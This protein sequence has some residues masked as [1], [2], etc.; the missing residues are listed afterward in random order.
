VAS[1]ILKNVRTWVD[2]Y[3]MTGDT[4]SGSLDLDHEVFDVTVNQPPGS[5]G[6]RARA[7]G[8]EDVSA[9]TSG[10]WSTGAGSVDEDAFTSLGRTDAVLTMSPDGLEG[11][12]AYTLRAGRLK[13]SLL[14][15]HGG[16]APFSLDFAG[17]HGETTTVRG[18]VVKTKG[19]VSATGATGTGQ[20]L[21]AVTA[22]QHLYASLHL[23][24]AGTTLTA[25]VES[26]DNSG[27]TSPTTRLTLGPVTAAGGVWA[28]RLAGPVT[29]TWYRLRISA[30]TGTFTIAAV[31]GIR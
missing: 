9:Q 31:V 7:C 8:L 30:I 19:A 25:V 12:V 15:A 10:F 4:N 1:T 11:S 18:L 2:G 6:A 26:D 17:S 21:G 20:Q 23:F 27:F 14:G 29:D 24:S 22:D 13:Y 5:G 28:T 16:P 3:D